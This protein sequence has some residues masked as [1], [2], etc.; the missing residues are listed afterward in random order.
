L[1]AGKK[2]AGEIHAIA[3]TDPG[4]ASF[5]KTPFFHCRVAKLRRAI[6]E[7]GADPFSVKATGFYRKMRMIDQLPTRRFAAVSLH[8]RKNTR[9][10]YTGKIGKMER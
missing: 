4:A 5:C 6:A 10:H 7:Q 3:C 8:G 9:N 2:A 1:P